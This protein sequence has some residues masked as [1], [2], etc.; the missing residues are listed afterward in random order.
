[1]VS[2]G[3]ARINATRVTRKKTIKLGN[4]ENNGNK[5]VRTAKKSNAMTEN[6]NDKKTSATMRKSK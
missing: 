5:A 4:K 6:N 2:D 1:V 3:T